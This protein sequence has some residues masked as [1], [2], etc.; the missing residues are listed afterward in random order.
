MSFQQ[1]NTNVIEIVRTHA[2]EPPQYATLYE[3]IEAVSE[4]LPP[5]SDR[6]VALI[7]CDMLDRGLVRLV[8]GNELLAA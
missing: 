8:E 7:V 2:K 3:L 1:K 4:Q 5:E 6:L